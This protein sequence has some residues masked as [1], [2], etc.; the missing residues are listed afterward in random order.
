MRVLVISNER[1][2]VSVGGLHGKANRLVFRKAPCE[3]AERDRIEIDL[4]SQTTERSASFSKV[5]RP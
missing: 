1:R 4:A 2:N 3:I 5:K